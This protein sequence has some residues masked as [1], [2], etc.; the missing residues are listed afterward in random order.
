M[1]AARQNDV[2]EPHTALAILQAQVRRSEAKY[3]TALFTW[4][5]ILSQKYKIVES[6]SYNK[7]IDA[8]KTWHSVP[9]GGLIPRTN[10]RTMQNRQSLPEEIVD[11]NQTTG[12][13]KAKARAKGSCG[14][15]A[16]VPLVKFRSSTDDR[17]INFRN[18]TTSAS[19]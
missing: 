3:I 18:D 17:V 5:D 11:T 2:L 6:V 9:S 13:V 8:N 10:L 4:Y 16:S 15:R 14:G 12:K 1:W 19:Q 7:I